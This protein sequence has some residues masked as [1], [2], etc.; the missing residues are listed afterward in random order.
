MIALPGFVQKG[1]LYLLLATALL[2]AGYVKGCT[3]GQ[4]DYVQFKAT[5]SAQ[6]AAQ[7]KR[8]AE[9]VRENKAEK[10][11]REAEYKRNIARLERDRERLRR[12]ARSSVVPPAPAEARDPSRATFDRAELDR[13]LREFTGEVAELVGEGAA[14][15]EGLDS[16]R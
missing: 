1:L 12:N 13:A 5:L 9:I 2:G 16:L 14:A 15:V 11:R 7:A 10:E 8:T 3:D 4:E 6:A